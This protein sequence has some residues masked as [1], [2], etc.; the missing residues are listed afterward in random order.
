M[1][2]PPKIKN[3][4]PPHPGHIRHAIGQ[5]EE[6][7]HGADIPD[8]FVI[9]AVLVQSDE[10]GVI[11]GT[12]IESDLHG[13]IQHGFLARR[14]IG[15]AVVDGDLIGDQRILGANAQDG[16]VGYHAVLAAVGV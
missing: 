14:D 5:A 7:R 11:D 10:I 9:E 4:V 1:Y 8:V 3:V 2:T 12:G 13:E 15:L 16:A 6:R